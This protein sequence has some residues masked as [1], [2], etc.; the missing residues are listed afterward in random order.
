MQQ[1]LL[2]P[3]WSLKQAE[4]TLLT[5]VSRL[6]PVCPAPCL[7]LT[8]GWPAWLHSCTLPQE[9]IPHTETLQAIQ[10]AQQYGCRSPRQ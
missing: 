5:R 3:N 6:N 9:N 7:P 2:D 10:S 4:L 1:L 8:R